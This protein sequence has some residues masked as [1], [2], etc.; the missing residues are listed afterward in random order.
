MC[1]VM[2]L[3]E[4][5]IVS[6]V[7]LRLHTILPTVRTDGGGSVSKG[8][9]SSRVSGNRGEVYELPGDCLLTEVGEQAASVDET[10]GVN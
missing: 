10:V 8:D 1:I 4:T 3:R 5:A 6:Q 7:K 9:Y 2:G